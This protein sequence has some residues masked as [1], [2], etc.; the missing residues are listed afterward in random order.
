MNRSEKYP[1]LDGLRA[2]AVIGIALM[3]ILT[4]S[5]IK[6][7]SCFVTDRLIPS[8][9]DFTLLFMTVSAFSMCCGYYDRIKSG[10]ITPNQFYSK[11]YSRLLPFFALMIVA[12]LVSSFSLD[13]L[14]EALAEVTLCFGLLPNPQM[15]I[16]GVG[17]FIGIIMIFYLLF[18]FFVFVIDSKNRGWLALAV[19]IMMCYLTITYFSQSQ[20]VTEP[21][22]RRNILYCFPFFMTGG[23]MYLYRSSLSKFSNKFRWLIPVAIIAVATSYFIA[24]PHQNEFVKLMWLNVLFSIGVI[25]CTGDFK[26]KILN[27]R[28][29]NLLSGISFEIYLCHMPAFRVL[30]RFHL[31]QYLTNGTVLYITQSALT[32]LIAIVLAYCIKRIVFPW[33]GKQL[34]LNRQ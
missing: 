9:T 13:S 30:E 21:H 11:R 31:Q 4:N 10:T 16:I 3:H 12:E 32:L 23:M 19:S 34:K 5:T 26:S 14:Y 25:Y 2:Y 7:A 33:V 1:L 8:F 15:H 24:N 17:W 18:P 22:G 20:F 29:V 28:V 6:P 27:N